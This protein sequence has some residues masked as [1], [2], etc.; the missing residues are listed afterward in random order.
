VFNVSEGFNWVQKTKVPTSSLPVAAPAAGTIV[1]IRIK[2]GTIPT[3]T[4]AGFRIFNGSF[5][6]GDPNTTRSHGRLPDK[7]YA[8]GTGAATD[9]VIPVDADG[10]PHGVPIAAGERLGLASVDTPGDAGLNGFTA[11]TAGG[12][13]I[14]YFDPVPGFKP[15]SNN[16]FNNRDLLVQYTIEPDADGDGYGDETQEFACGGQQATIVG[17]AGNDVLTGTPGNDVIA[18]LDGNDT[19]VASG[20][21]DVVCGG[22]GND[23]LKGGA[24]KDKLLGEAGKDTLKGGGGTKDVC[25][26]GPG[27]DIARKCEKVRS[28]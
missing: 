9:T 11:I 27:P 26:G 25:K 13:V 10:R 3:A 14:N 23:I 21:D 20:G 19:V 4:A 16:T 2:H 5:V 7:A 15:N 24:G 18:A 6:D 12:D 1:S 17:T 8:A 22:N 28:L